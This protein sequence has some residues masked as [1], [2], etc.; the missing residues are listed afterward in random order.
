[1]GQNL[2]HVLIESWWDAGDWDGLEKLGRHVCIECCSEKSLSPRP[3]S[4]G[5]YVP[6]RPAWRDQNAGG[7]SRIAGA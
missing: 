4:A 3:F 6:A 2:Q 7:R 1:M 5:R